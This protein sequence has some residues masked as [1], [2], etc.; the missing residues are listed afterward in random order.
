[1]HQHRRHLLAALALVAL[2]A[3]AGTSRADALV[4]SLAGDARPG[5]AIRVGETGSGLAFCSVRRSEEGE[6]NDEA[7]EVDPAST[8]HLLAVILAVPAGTTPTTNPGGGSPPV[9]KSSSASNGGPP[10]NGGSDGG[11]NGPPPSNMAPEPGSLLTA[12]IG[13]ALLGL[14]VRRRRRRWLRPSV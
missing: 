6:G 11:S 12:L 14:A 13:S 5:A 9:V 10:S 4:T 1:M 2:M 7:A 3:R 8:L